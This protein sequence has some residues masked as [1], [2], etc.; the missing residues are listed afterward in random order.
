MILSNKKYRNTV[1]GYYK[2]TMKK[3]DYYKLLFSTPPIK[4][5]DVPIKNINSSKRSVKGPDIIEANEPIT[6]LLKPIESTFEREHKIF[7][8]LFDEKYIIDEIFYACDFPKLLEKIY[9]NSNYVSKYVVSLYKNDPVFSV[10]MGKVIIVHKNQSIDLIKLKQDIRKI[11]GFDFYL[12]QN[13]KNEKLIGLNAIH[14]PDAINMKV[15]TAIIKEH[16]YE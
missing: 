10:Q 16:K 8:Y 14:I 4:L 13:G 15:E 12:L 7:K 5:I 9:K 3:L 1:N 6:L 2:Q 11:V